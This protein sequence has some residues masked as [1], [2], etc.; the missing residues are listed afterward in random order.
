M[1]PEK[2]LSTTAP[3]IYLATGRLR[4]LTPASLGTNPATTTPSISPNLHNLDFLPS[5]RT[6][7][8]GKPSVKE[9]GLP[10]AATQKQAAL[11]PQPVMY[12]LAG[13]GG[14]TFDKWTPLAELCR[15]DLGSGV[16]SWLVYLPT[17]MLASSSALPPLSADSY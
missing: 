15:G 11:G 1:M 12:S 4:L 9:E 5:N 7:G 6:E 14:G 2:P 8:N 17:A 13:P 3:L 10:A 16:G